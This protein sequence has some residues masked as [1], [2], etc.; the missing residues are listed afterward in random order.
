ML[1]CGIRIL[2]NLRA[3]GFP[4]PPKGCGNRLI[5]EDILQARRFALEACSWLKDIENLSS[6][7]IIKIAIDAPRR[8]RLSQL[9]VRGSELALQKANIQ[10]I[11]T[12]PEQ[13]FVEKRKEAA[14]HLQAG[15]PVASL[16]GANLWWM[17]VGFALFDTFAQVFIQPCPQ[18]LDPYRLSF[19]PLCLNV[20][21]MKGGNSRI[22]HD[23]DELEQ[24][25][26]LNQGIPADV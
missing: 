18:V 1:R 2:G 9:P 20:V 12:P 13:D 15:K 3:S 23:G 16:P 17:C 6:D 7:K 10:F 11:K 8:P 26:V 25:R 5:A 22:Q 4:S 14:I 24:S 21:G 19:L